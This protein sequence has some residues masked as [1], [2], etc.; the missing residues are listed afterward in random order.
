MRDM[1]D[2]YNTNLSASESARYE[3]WKKEQSKIVGRDITS[4][5]YNYDL[6]GFWKENPDFSYSDPSQHLNDTYKKPN[7]PTFSNESIYHGKDGYEGGEWI[8]DGEVW[9][10]K[11]S[12]TNIKMSGNEGL[13]EYFKNN[14]PSVELIVPESAASVLFGGDKG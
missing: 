9:Q 14:E 2:K 13:Q 5:E 8:Q 4:D 7:H 6:R 1:S 11:A 12:P 3:E 10:F